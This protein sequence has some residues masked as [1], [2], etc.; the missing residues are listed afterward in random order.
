MF[1]RKNEM[2]LESPY[3]KPNPSYEFSFKKTNLLRAY[4]VPGTVFVGVNETKVIAFIELTF[5]WHTNCG[6][7]WFEESLNKMELGM[8]R[9]GKILHQC[10][11]YKN[12]MANHEFQSLLPNREI[13][14]LQRTQ[15]Q[16]FIYS[17]H[18]PL[19][20]SCTSTTHLQTQSVS[21]L[22]LHLIGKYLL[23]L[24]VACCWSNGER[25][26]YLFICLS[27]KL[28]FLTGLTSY[29]VENVFH[30]SSSG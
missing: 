23:P 18:H 8:P 26:L 15:F 2:R 14:D 28:S 10:W 30:P 22:V 19:P 20:R 12:V 6:S 4:Y 9:T 7:Y 11:L 29:P 16:V 17:A 3:V 1:A 24:L 13:C 27:Y 25:Q 21:C 5:W